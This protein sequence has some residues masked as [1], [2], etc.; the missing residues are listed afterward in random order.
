MVP[1]DPGVVQVSFWDRDPHIPGHGCPRYAQI[2]VPHR[3]V[4]SDPV[5]TKTEVGDDSD[6]KA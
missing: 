4:T 6:K 1:E 2:L 3:T 5:Q